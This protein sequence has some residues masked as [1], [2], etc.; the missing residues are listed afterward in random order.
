MLIFKVI[1]VEPAESPV[2]SGGAPGPHKIQGIGAGFIPG[3]L[4]TELI[5]E[6][7]QVIPHNKHADACALLKCP[8]LGTSSSSCVVQ[9]LKRQVLVTWIRP[10]WQAWPDPGQGVGHPLQGD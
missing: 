2:I 8:I 5:D 3:N 6:V 1:A 9:L 4:D 7:V 10:G